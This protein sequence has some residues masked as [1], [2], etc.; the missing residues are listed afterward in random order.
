MTK[1]LTMRLIPALMMLGFAGA[2]GA[3][4]FALQNQSGS[5]NGNAFAGA[6]AAAE[7]ASTIYFNPAGMTYLPTGHTIALSGTILDRSIKYKDTGSVGSPVP[8]LANARA[9]GGDAGGTAFL[10]H[11]YWAWSVAPDVWFGVGVGPTFGNKSE[12]DTNFIGRNAG[13]HTE[14]EQININPSFAIK[15]NDMLSLGLGVNLAHASLRLKQGSPGTGGYLD[16]DGDAWGFGA[17]IGAMF[18]LSPSTRIG[19]SYRSEIDFDIEGDLKPNGLSGAAAVLFPRQKV[20]A[21]GYT[22][23][24]TFSMAV[25]QKLSDRWE[26]LG[27]LTRTNWSSIDKLI[28]RSENG[29]PAAGIAADGRLTALDYS[30]RNTWRV[31]LGANYQYNE[32]WKF[33]FGVAY[34]QSPVAKKEDRTMTLPDSDRIWLSFGTK[35]NLSKAASLDV[36][37]SHIFFRD[38][39]TSRAVTS[40]PANTTVL[41]TINGEWNNNRA[42]L[43]SVQYNH[44]F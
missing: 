3:S 24:G 35:Y 36:A 10:P 30:F 21:D 31:G 13:Y 17:N 20:V 2:A 5:G 15:V 19:L 14:I 9:N 34:D 42:D 32:A 22:T 37:Y 6:A 41:Q 11:G 1:G 27:D 16:I 26:L 40:P 8:F 43:L 23:P 33:R 44:T 7:D 39:K 25:S 29:V 12:Y 28:L 38:A 18:Q 4:G